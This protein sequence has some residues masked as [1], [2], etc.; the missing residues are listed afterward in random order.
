MLI[1]TNSSTGTHASVDILGTRVDLHERRDIKMWLRAQL[2]GGISCAHVVTL[3]PEYVMV[4]RRDDAFEMILRGAELVTI[5]G[6]GVEVA[7]KMIAPGH[8]AERVTGVDLTW[9]LADISTEIGAR[10][11]LLGAGPGVAEKAADVLRQRLPGAVIVGTWAEGSPHEVH[12]A[13]A[14]RRIKES[15]PDVLLVA[16]GA[17]GQVT[18]IDRNRAALADAGVKIVIGVGGALDYVS[19]A[20]PWAPPLVRKLGLEWLYRLVR[21]PWRW[22]RQLVLPVF[23]ALVM[24]DSVLARMRNRKRQVA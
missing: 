18:W 9:M 1:Y 15:C 13:E 6:I 17:P 23:A 22:R 11:F 4:A 3:N 14:V 2:I 8:A 20:V 12:D 21:E 19:G 7:V 5:D 16:Y 10:I 24:R